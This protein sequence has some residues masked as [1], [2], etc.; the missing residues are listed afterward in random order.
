VGVLE[1]TTKYHSSTVP[2]AG[3][4]LLVNKLLKWPSPSLLLPVVDTLR[5]LVLHSDG[6]D[7]LLEVYPGGGDG[8]I[9]GLLELI[10]RSASPPELRGV[11]L[12]LARVLFNSFRHAKLRETVYANS[13][14]IIS[15]VGTTLMD[16][17]H[18]TVKAAAANCLYNFGSLFVTKRRDKINDDNSTISAGLAGASLG[19]A[20]ILDV[21]MSFVHQAIQAAIGGLSKVKEEEPLY[22]LIVTLGTLVAIETST[23]GPYAKAQGADAA[24]ATASQAVKEASIE[25]RSCMSSS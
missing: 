10:Q 3:V 15:V 4:S 25:L 7:A 1:Q 21:D 20:P 16:Y 2:R 8:F 11:I 14:K 17:E 23:L 24:L 9:A 6:V 5:L 12:T 18:P 19:G 13:S 22:R